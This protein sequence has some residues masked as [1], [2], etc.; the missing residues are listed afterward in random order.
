MFSGRSATAGVCDSVASATRVRHVR[1]N[2]GVWH[3]PPAEATAATY[4][5]RYQIWTPSQVDATWLRNIQFLAE[6]FC[7]ELNTVPAEVRN[8]IKEAAKWHLGLSIQEIR[9]SCEMATADHINILI[10]HDEL[11]IELT[12]ASLTEPGKVQVFVSREAAETYKLLT[13]KESN[14][15]CGTNNDNSSVIPLSS[16]TLQIITSASP[17]DLTVAI[18]R[19]RILTDPE[20]AKANPV[21]DRT[22]RNWCRSFRLAKERFSH[23]LLDGFSRRILAFHL[24]FDPPSY[25]TLMMLIRRCVE[26]HGRLPNT[27]IVDGSKEFRSI[28]FETLTAAYEIVTKQR[29]GGKP[30]YGSLIERMFGTVNTQF[31]HTLKGNKSRHV[32]GGPF[33]DLSKRATVILTISCYVR[34]RTESSAGL[35]F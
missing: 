16:E 18:R 35:I 20:F 9:G 3:W 8:Q 22:R 33:V 30:R 4:G 15:S 7:A 14:S 23:V 34:F 17:E 26:R 28:Y 1:A 32:Q 25:R 24:T 10:A 27:L 13:G 29:P 2:D 31:L 19:Y 6:Y 11:Y 12:A 21:P 5:Y